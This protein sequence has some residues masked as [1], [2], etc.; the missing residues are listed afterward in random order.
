MMGVVE[1]VAPSS[2]APGPLRAEERGDDRRDDAAG[3]GVDWRVVVRGALIGFGVIVP[4]AT[5]EAVLRHEIRRF[6]TSGWIY[7]LF[8]L[9]L[10]GYAAAG[11]VAGRARPDTP[12]MHG[13]LAG[14]GAFALWVPTRIVIWAV[15]EDGRGLFSGD[16]AALRPGQVYGAIV[17]AVSIGMLGAWIGCWVARRRDAQALG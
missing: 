7:P 3:D 12:L 14:L 1:S 9:V 4:V 6:D 11:W 15:R 13:T 17:I 5:L 16:H 2:A 10:V 8:V